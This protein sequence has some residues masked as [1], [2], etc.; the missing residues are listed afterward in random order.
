[1]NRIELMNKVKN[2]LAEYGI[3]CGYDCRGEMNPE[4]KEKKH[5]GTLEICIPERDITMKAGIEVTQFI[6]KEYLM[7]KYVNRVREVEGIYGY[8]AMVVV[9]EYIPEKSRELLRKKG[10]NYADACGNIYVNCNKMMIFVDGKANLY[11]KKPKVNLFND[12]GIA[13][14]ERLL[15]VKRS[16]WHLKDI[17]EAFRVKCDACPVELSV[18]KGYCRSCTE[19]ASWGGVYNYFRAYEKEGFIYQ[20]KDTKEW[21]WTVP[22]ES[23]D[24]GRE[25]MRKRIK[26]EKEKRG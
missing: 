10:L 23:G 13:T 15:K 16:S 6:Y 7:K 5:D 26:D 11:A 21:S 19:G 2:N 9:T 8:D 18:R 3:L 25:R 20:D 22:D 24:D 17:A 14:A 12:K 4:G 1:M